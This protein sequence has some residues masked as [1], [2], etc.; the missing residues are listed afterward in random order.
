MIHKNRNNRVSPLKIGRKVLMLLA[1]SICCLPACNTEDDLN[2]TPDSLSIS[3]SGTFENENGKAFEAGDGNW[4]VNIK[5]EFGGDLQVEIQADKSWGVNIEYF[6]LEDDEWIT[7]ST[8]ESTGDNLTLSI[9]A[10]KSVLYRKAAVTIRTQGDVP[11]EKKITIIQTD[12]EPIIEFMPQ[13]GGDSS[14]DSDTKTLTVEYKASEQIIDF[15]SNIEDYTL[16]VR[17]ENEGEDISWIQ[18]FRV[19]EEER[20]LTF[21]TTHN[22]TGAPRRAMITLEADGFETTTYYL[23]Q[24]ASLYKN[25]LVSIDGQPYTSELEGITYGMKERTISIVFDSDVELS[26]Q[27]LDRTTSAEASWGSL[28]ASGNTFT[29]TLRANIEGETRHEGLLQ[30]KAADA[31]LS[32]QPAVEWSFTQLYEMLTIDWPESSLYE[33]G[34][35]IG[36]IGYTDKSLGSYTSADEDVTAEITSGDTWLSVQL[37]DGVIR[38]N[39]ES[40]TGSSPRTATLKIANPNGRLSEEITL[41]QYAA[42][43]KSAWSIE[44]GN[45]KTGSTSNE[46]ISNIIDGDINTHWQWQWNVNG[47]AS[48]DFPNTP[49]EFIIDFGKEEV[50]NTISLWQTQTADNGYVRDVQFKVSNDKASWTDLGVYRMSNSSDDAIAHGSDPYSYLLPAVQKARYVRLMILSNVDDSKINNR[51]NAYMGEFSISID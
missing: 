51:K 18:G 22:F 47:G 49:Y 43:D 20:T 25:L 38:L 21:S 39:A 24:K 10:N 19:S 27:L 17:P 37:A 46:P 35:I 40:Y 9:A 6:T 2:W 8:V 23:E 11:V 50:F 33:N 42:I 34:L 48:S 15:W 45:D 31:S 32:D 5:P 13:E 16:Q 29:L 3:V 12:S 26:A 41:T 7:P 30:V 1:A 36:G 4:G 44:A 14:F 28:E